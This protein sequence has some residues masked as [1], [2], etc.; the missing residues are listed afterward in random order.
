MTEFEKVLQECLLDL[1]QGDTNVE[2]CLS[3]HP[4]YA[5]QLEPVLL[6]SLDLELG[7]EARPSPAFKARVR[8]KLTQEMLAHPRRAIRLGFMLRR[9]ATSFAMIVLALVVA[10]TVYAQGALPGQPFYSW[11]LASE[12]IWRAVSPDPVGTDLAIAERRADEL[13]AVGDNPAQRAQIL[14]AYLA[15]LTRL[16]LETNAAN[17]ARIHLV[18]DSQ[19]EE[20]N[21]S[22]VSLPGVEQ[23][24]VPPLEEPIVIPT[25]TPFVLPEI[26]QG[27]P[28]LPI[29]AATSLPVHE[30][31]QSSSTDSPKII[32]T[33]PVKTDSVPTIQVPSL[34]P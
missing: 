8:A 19:L 30:S 16:E 23:N 9:L 25:A 21:Q 34:I 10:G 26:P 24:I 2:E 5:L 31:T 12:N 18:L 32:P 15:V 4:K 11:K 20:L 1:E 33:L 22:G 17:E 3:R 7:R 13:I 6:T 29:S 28:T 27:N 14:E